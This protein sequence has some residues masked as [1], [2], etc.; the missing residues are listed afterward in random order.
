MNS[1]PSP[2]HIHTGNQLESLTQTIDS[3][4]KRQDKTSEQYNN[5]LNRYKKELILI[6]ES[7][8]K[9]KKDI[10]DTISSLK[11]KYYFVKFL[12]KNT[13]TISDS[14]IQATITCNDNNIIFQKNEMLKYGI[15][16]VELLP[17][18]PKKPEKPKLN[19]YGFNTLESHNSYLPHFEN[20]HLDIQDPNAYRKKVEIEDQKCFVLLKDLH[21]G[22]EADLFNIDLIIL[23]EAEIKFE[24]TV[25]SKESTRTLCPDVVIVEEKMPKTLYPQKG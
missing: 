9:Y 14:N 6:S 18:V 13:G 15:N 1:L 10:H 24:A 17:V 20:L 4:L 11:Q 21:V 19:I 8:P 2:I 12:I 16:L 3:V 5:E 23:N 25:R 22:G 7:I